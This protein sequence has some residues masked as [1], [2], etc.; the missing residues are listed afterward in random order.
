VFST[1]GDY[2]NEVST[3]MTANDFDGILTDDSGFALLKSCRIFSARSLKLT[4]KGSLETKELFLQ[5]MLSDKDIKPAHWPLLASLLGKKPVYV[6]S[7]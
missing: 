3:Y 5:K 7:T 4:Y 6:F 2:Y 1:L